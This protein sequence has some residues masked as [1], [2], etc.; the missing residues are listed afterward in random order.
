MNA[1]QRKTRKNRK[2]ISKSYFKAIRSITEIAWTMGSTSDLSMPIIEGQLSFP[3]NLIAKWIDRVQLAGTRDSFIAEKF[4]RVAALLDPPASL[5]TPGF[6]WRVLRVN[7]KSRL[8]STE[9]EPVCF[10]N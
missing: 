7:R 3:N 10:E 1:W 2:N 5:L 8:E 6:V 4:V 9:R